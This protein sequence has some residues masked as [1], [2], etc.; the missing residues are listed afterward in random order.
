MTT[1]TVYKNVFA[2]EPWEVGLDDVDDNIVDTH[3]LPTFTVDDL[4]RIHTRYDEFLYADE[5]DTAP[6]PPFN[7]K[8]YID[9]VAAGR[10]SAQV[11][12]TVTW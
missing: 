9:L 4:K 1:E 10:T 11:F 8:D 3:Q 12:L 2:D 5:H 6:Q 7:P